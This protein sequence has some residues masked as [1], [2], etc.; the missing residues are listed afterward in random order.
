MSSEHYVLVTEVSSLPLVQQTALWEVTHTKLQ[1]FENLETIDAEN[2]Y[3]LNLTIGHP[4][5]IGE[6]QIPGSELAI[7]AFTFTLLVFILCCHVCLHPRRC[8]KLICRRPR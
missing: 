8:W 4:K 5:R 2:K 3:E 1:T 6:L 7:P